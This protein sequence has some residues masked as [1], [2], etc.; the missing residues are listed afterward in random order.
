LKS[1]L[2]KA[3][4]RLKWTAFLQAIFDA[5]DGHAP[6]GGEVLDYL[7]RAPPGGVSGW[8]AGDLLG[9]AAG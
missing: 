4:A 7:L 1:A 2:A 9:G 3:G 8:M 6:G 5:G